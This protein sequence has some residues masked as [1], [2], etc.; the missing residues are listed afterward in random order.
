MLPGGTV[1]P[2]QLRG[3]L[4]P[5]V[6]PAI[7]AAVGACLRAHCGRDM[8]RTG[9]PVPS[10]YAGMSSQGQSSGVRGM[11]L[12]S[13]VFDFAPTLCGVASGLGPGK[14]CFGRRK[15]QGALGKLDTSRPPLV[16]A[17]HRQQAQKKA[18]RSRVAGTRGITC[19]GTPL[20]TREALQ[21]ASAHR[22]VSCRDCGNVGCPG[23]DKTTGRSPS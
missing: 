20:K 19:A 21:E 7:V 23:T 12:R 5:A 22:V 14:A 6:P 10:P 4:C 2:G 15:F 1:I 11:G 18:P 9:L 13:L 8:A 16:A 17:E 3:S